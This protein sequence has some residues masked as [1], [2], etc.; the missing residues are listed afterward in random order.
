MG[1]AARLEKHDLLEFR[2]RELCPPPAPTRDSWKQRLVVLLL[3]Q[4]VVEGLVDR[5]DVVLLHRD[6][7]VL[8][9]CGLHSDQ[10]LPHLGAEEQHPGGQ[11]GLQRPLDRGGGLL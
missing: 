1:L 9:H 8:D 5:R 10:E 3:D 7:V 11:R 4:E 6:E 2:R